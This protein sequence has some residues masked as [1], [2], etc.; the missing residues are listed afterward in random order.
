LD[1]PR[2][3][4]AI[5]FQRFVELFVTPAVIFDFDGVL[6]DSERHHYAAYNAVFQKYGHTLDEAEYYK[7]WTSLGLGPAG[8]V[9]RHGLSIDPD[10]IRREK[11]PAF[12]Q[13]CRDGVV[14]FFPESRELVVVLSR[15]GKTLAIASGTMVSDINAILENEK[16]M[17]RFAVVAGS[18]TVPALKPAPDI[19]LYVQRELGIAARDALVI[20]DAEKGI[21]AARAAGMPVVVVRTPETGAIDFS[22]ADL[23]LESHAELLSFARRAFP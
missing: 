15:A 23:V 3:S 9:E 18:D 17:E 4:A 21:G 1:K 7:Y 14:Q 22:A 6:V 16:L 13:L 2:E 12:S 10:A 5:R 20:E 8:E 19:L 11:R